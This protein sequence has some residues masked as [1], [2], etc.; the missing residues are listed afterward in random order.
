MNLPPH[1]DNNEKPGACRRASVSVLEQRNVRECLIYGDLF[2]MIGTTSKIHRGLTL[3][4]SSPCVDFAT[5]VA[6][7]VEKKNF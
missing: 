7:R 1:F 6:Y 2:D 3:V 4:R 5:T